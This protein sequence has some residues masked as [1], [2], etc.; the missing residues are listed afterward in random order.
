MISSTAD[1]TKCTSNPPSE[2]RKDSGKEERRM[3]FLNHTGHAEQSPRFAA[4]D[5][6]LREA[7]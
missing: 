4:N 6:S 2:E 3:N 1:P 5:P 7:K